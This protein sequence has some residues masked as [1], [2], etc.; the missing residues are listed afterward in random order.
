MFYYVRISLL[1]TELPY[2]NFIFYTLVAKNMKKK[3]KKALVKAKK[4]EKKPIP[5]INEIKSILT[6]LQR[7]EDRLHRIMH[8]LSRT[9]MEKFSQKTKKSSKK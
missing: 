4:I 1:L 2:T 8:D 7:Q 9:K 3:V 6:D 5:S